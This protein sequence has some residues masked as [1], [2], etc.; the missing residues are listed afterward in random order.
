L[1]NL[2]CYFNKFLNLIHLMYCSNQLQVT[3]KFK[4]FSIVQSL[5][6]F[7]GCRKFCPRNQIIHIL[8]LFFSRCCLCLTPL[9]LFNLSLHW[10]SFTRWVLGPWEKH[11]QNSNYPLNYVLNIL[12]TNW[13][14]LIWNFFFFKFI[15]MSDVDSNHSS[16]DGSPS[17]KIS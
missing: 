3:H 5:Q 6:I 14:V 10:F 7:L 9:A 12:K 13:K 16:W 8:F 15:F 1:L 4:N 17:M 2:H 11:F